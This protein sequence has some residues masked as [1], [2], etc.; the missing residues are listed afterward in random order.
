MVLLKK[1]K[2]ISYGILDIFFPRRCVICGRPSAEHYNNL[3]D[4]CLPAIPWIL[5]QRCIFCSRPMGDIGTCEQAICSNCKKQSFPY[6]DRTACWLHTGVGRDIILALKY[7]K[8]DFLQRDITRL[9]RDF[10][11]DIVESVRDAVIVPVPVPYL[12]YLQ[13]GYNQAMVIARAICSATTG[14]Y[15]MELLRSGYKRSQTSLNYHSR[16]KNV[17][18]VFSVNSTYRHIP[19]ERRIVLVD[20]VATT[21]STVNEC[22]RLLQMLGFNDLHVLTLSYG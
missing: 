7:R 20:D 17:Q 9:I 13:R 16:K 8:A 3:C 2:N 21:G 10:R 1:L 5:C 22:C 4:A 6:V 19:R 12:R 14:A 18:G 11:Q 15:V